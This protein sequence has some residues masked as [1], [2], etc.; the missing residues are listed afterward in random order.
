[1]H[2]AD[3]D[4]QPDRAVRLARFQEQH[5]SAR[6][7]RQTVRENAAGSTRTNNDEIVTLQLALSQH[8]N[9]RPGQKLYDSDQSVNRLYSANRERCFA[10]FSAVLGNRLE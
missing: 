5:A 7:G 4:V 8:T 9:V 10:G 1:M 3:R 2:V 6:I